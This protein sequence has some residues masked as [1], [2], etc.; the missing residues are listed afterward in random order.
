[1][2]GKERERELLTSVLDS[3]GFG[4]SWVEKETE[5]ENKKQRRTRM[6]LQRTRAMAERKITRF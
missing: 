3:F 6:E 5:L 1:M 4:V 2:R